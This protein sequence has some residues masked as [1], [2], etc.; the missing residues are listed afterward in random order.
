MFY[1]GIVIVAY[2]L[3]FIWILWSFIDVKKGD[4]EKFNRKGPLILFVVILILSVVVNFYLSFA[5]NLSFFQNGF[6]SMIGLIVIGSLWVIIAI[7]NIIT[8]V[9]ARQK[10]LSKTLHNPKVVWIFS[11]V[12]AGTLLI[13]FLWFM[14]LGNKISYAVTLNN[15][16]SAME[17]SSENKEISLVQV[18]SESD[19]FRRRN[20]DEE[21]KNVFYVRNNLDNTKEVQL[22]IYALDAN[23]EELKVID[24]NIMELEPGEI[25]MVKTEETNEKRNIWSQP[26][27]K[28]ERRVVYYKYNYRYRNAE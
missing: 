28:T 13:F 1:M 7:I 3:P 18:L 9:I 12:F 8:T 2:L 14:P 5:Y 27:F 11:G 6:T 17:N 23:K 21:Y 19:C 24:S 20:C 22:Q 26:T 10:N 15:A 4:K 25:Q 16:I